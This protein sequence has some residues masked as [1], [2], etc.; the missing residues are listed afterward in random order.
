MLTKIP[1]KI[2][3]KEQIL[4]KDLCREACRHFVSQIFT[5]IGSGTKAE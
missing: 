2:K 4:L 1:N 5:A 3:L